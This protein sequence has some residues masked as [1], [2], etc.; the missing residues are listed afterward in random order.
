MSHPRALNRPVE[1]HH[2]AVKL[3]A[4]PIQSGLSLAGRDLT[5][6]TQ[7]RR[8]IEDQREVRLDPTGSRAVSG[9]DQRRIQATPRHLIGF[10]RE[11][12]SIREYYPAC[13]QSRPDDGL[14]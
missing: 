3:G 12:K 7:L 5:G 1:I 14:N 4:L 6:L 10:G 13:L 9:S 11:R 8:Q 2:P